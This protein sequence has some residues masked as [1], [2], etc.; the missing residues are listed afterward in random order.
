MPQNNSTVEKKLCPQAFITNVLPKDPPRCT[1][2]S[3]MPFAAGLPAVW[4]GEVV[5]KP[6]CGGTWPSFMEGHDYPLMRVQGSLMTSSVLAF[7]F[8]H[9]PRKAVYMVCSL[10][11]AMP[12]QIA[13]KS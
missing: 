10:L 7:V 3:W 5:G 13:I 8:Q 12:P 11:P 4:G 1:S 2:M 9:A 6:G